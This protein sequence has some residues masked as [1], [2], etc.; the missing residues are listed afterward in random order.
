MR[1]LVIGDL[2]FDDKPLGMMEA[3]KNA[4]INISKGNTDCNKIIFL[5]DLMMHR[6]PRPT[7]LIALK[8]LIDKLTERGL[9][10]YILRGNHDSVT[11]ADDGV[12]AL[13]LFESPKVKV[14]T[15]TY[16]DHEN[17]WV[18]IPHYENEETIKKDLSLCPDGYIIFGHFGYNGVLNS[19]G[20]A[21]FNLSLSDFSN[22]TILGHIHKAGQNGR[23]TVLGTPYT[24]SFN[25]S[26]K[27]CFYGILTDGRLELVP[28]ELGPKHIVIDY[29]SV[30]E[31]LDWIRQY[32][33]P[34]KYALV[35]LNINTIAQDQHNAAAIC[36]SLKVPY[37][38]IKY[39]PLLDDDEEFVTGSNPILNVMD[40]DVID[41][42]INS[43]NVS[44]PKEELL[45]GL[46]IIYENQQG[47]NN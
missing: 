25:E 39:K 26:G 6:N 32:S 14:I 38:E 41:H 16:I 28:V 33:G 24:T 44:I 1:T 19:A 43:S 5:G 30:E 29:D 46:K 12:T 11:K 45:A 27:D 7:V 35:R 17:K 2:H 36:D 10:V 18:F 13:S 23:V 42:Y 34:D 22:P 20:D 47:R 15:H 21:D 9:D 31:N 40:N 37:V 8:E 3:Q 4:I